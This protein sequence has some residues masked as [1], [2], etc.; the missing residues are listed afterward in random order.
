MD[1]P[2][3]SWRNNTAGHKQSRSFLKSISDSFLTQMTEI[4]MRTGALQDLV[5]TPKEGLVGDVKVEGSLG[6]GS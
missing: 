5:L 6:S 3:S 2:D 1:H 4:P